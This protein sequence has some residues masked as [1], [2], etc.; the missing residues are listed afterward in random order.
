MI[1][2]LLPLPFSQVRK[3]FV[4]RECQSDG[5][6]LGVGVGGGVVEV[7]GGGRG[8]LN[9]AASIPEEEEEGSYASAS[10][11]AEGDVEA[12]TAAAE[13]G[14]GGLRSNRGA[15]ARRAFKRQI[16]VQKI[17]KVFKVIMFSVFLFSISF[18]MGKNLVSKLSKQQASNPYRGGKNFFQVDSYGRKKVWEESLIS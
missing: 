10:A 4:Y 8:R 2:A 6:D 11:S 7:R 5:N 3:C 15:K 9:R 17:A 13:G 18:W 1:E 12:A 16:T 14:G